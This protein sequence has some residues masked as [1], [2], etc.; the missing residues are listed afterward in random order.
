MNKIMNGNVFADGRGYVSF[1][2]DFDFKNVKRFYMVDN[3]ED[4]GNFYIVNVSVI[5]PKER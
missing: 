5:K 3:F 2:N 4:A 1:V